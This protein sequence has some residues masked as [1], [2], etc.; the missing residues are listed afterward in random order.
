MADSVAVN[1]ISETQKTSLVRELGEDKT[2][3]F[4]TLF[5]DFFAYKNAENNVMNVL[6]QFSAGELEYISKL[7]PELGEFIRSVSAGAEGSVFNVQANNKNG[8]TSKKS[9][10][11]TLN[12]EI[13]RLEVEINQEKTRLETKKI[14]RDDAKKALEN[15]QKEYDEAKREY[16]A[17]QEEYEDINSEIEKTSEGLE[18]SK[19][20]EQQKAISKAMSE[21]N[22]AEDGEWGAYLEK[23]LA[24]VVGDTKLKTLL[25]NLT[26]KSSSAARELGTLQLKVS[27][28][29]EL[30]SVNQEKYNALNVEVG[31]LENSIS[32]NEATKTELSKELVQVLMDSISPEER[33]YVIANKI[34]LL[35]KNTDG[36]PKYTFTKD[37]STGGYHIYKANECGSGCEPLTG[38]RQMEREEVS[39]LSLDLNG[40]GVKTSSEIVEFD[41]DGDGVMDRIND[42]ADGVLVFD[43]DRDGKAGKDGSECFGDKTDLD[44]DGV[45]DGYKNGFEALKALAEKEGLTGGNDHILDE[46][47]IKYLEEKFGFGIKTKGYNSDVQSLTDLGITEINLANTEETKLEDNFDNMG[48]QLMTQDGATF[49]QNGETKEYADI[50]HKKH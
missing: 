35:E 38:F 41:I 27:G 8:E 42:S 25:E 6:G 49:V 36:S 10:V 11:D 20:E 24:G 13:E 30:I 14:E 18:E 26:G 5:E 45:G 12:A 16:E 22:E 4:I 7:D 3:K 31:N 48:N 21:Y 33:A 15:A 23:Q 34:N 2:K 9:D 29:K 17:K 44:G 28:K 50:W 43:K 32:T 40:D 46:K 1:T 47:D 19:K 39:P 37:E